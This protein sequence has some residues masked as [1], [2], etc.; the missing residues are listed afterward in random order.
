LGLHQSP[1][2]A[3]GIKINFFGPRGADFSEDAAI[4]PSAR[5][6][7]SGPETGSTPH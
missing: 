4:D 7:S 6:I 3:T 1:I 2:S 5:L